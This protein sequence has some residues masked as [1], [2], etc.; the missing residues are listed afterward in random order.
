MLYCKEDFEVKFVVQ[1][2]SNEAVNTFFFRHHPFQRAYAAVNTNSRPNTIYYLSK[3]N[4][5]V[6]ARKFV[7]SVLRLTSFA[8]K[9]NWPFFMIQLNVLMF[10]NHYCH[11][12]QIKKLLPLKIVW[13]KFFLSFLLFNQI[14]VTF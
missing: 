7:K 4:I 2:K 13:F 14:L 11:E 8:H 9:W 10:Q 3:W 1:S 5:N 12:Y 6:R